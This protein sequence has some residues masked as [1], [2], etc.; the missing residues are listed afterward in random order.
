MEAHSQLVDICVVCALPD[1][2]RAFLEV[3]RQQCNVDFEEHIDRQHKYDYRLTT[4]GNDRGESLALHVSWLPRYGPQEM[5]LHLQRVLEVYQP[6][7]AIMTGIC[8]GDSQQVQLGDLIVAE[9]TFTYDS[10]KFMVDKQGRS[11]HL[12][13]TLTYQL[14]ANILQFL[15]LFD[16]WEPLIASLE[17]PLSA[18]EQREIAC[19]LKP[20][21]SGN[22]VRA[23]HPFE[24]VRAPVRGTVA[25]DMEGAAFGLV[26]SR[27]PLIRWLVVK[28]VCDYADHDKN[29]VYHDY[30]ARAS[31]LYALSFIQAYIT[32]ERL[33]RL[34]GP[35]PS[36]RAGPP[37]AWNVPYRRNPFFTGREDLLTRLHKRLGTTGA[38]ALTQ[39]QAISG[40][41]GIGKTQTAVDYAYR[42][43][44]EYAYVLW[45]QAASRDTLIT[46]F[47]T[48]ANLLGLPVQDEPDQIRVAAVKQWFSEHSGW[49]LILDNAD[50]MSLICEFLPTTHDRGHILLTTRAQATGA[51][52]EP[53]T[54]EKLGLEEGV[55]LLLRRARKVDQAGAEDRLAARAIVEAMD[56]LPLALDQAGAYIEE[57]QCSVSDY[58]QL[59]QTHQSLLL[60]RRGFAVC[61]LSP[62]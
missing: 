55:Q 51:I 21:A 43:R 11:I 18:P 32:N 13:D 57:T 54:V 38:A 23:D 36:S 1:E 49:L 7:I 31:A 10:G 39:A 45:V 5:V 3:I 61:D 24:E 25:I 27:Y 40:L 41:G 46:D 16:K 19:H 58:L 34:D 12:H 14:D 53:V 17:R 2:V 35:S 50:D 44:E 30:A 4:I 15:G 20:M 26:M 59:Y 8:A 6:R 47:V 28:G 9:R 42:F 62:P 22:A 52:A 48:I 33:P 60:R 56:G 37:G 29:D